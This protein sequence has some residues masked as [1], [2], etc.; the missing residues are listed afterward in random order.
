MNILIDKVIDLLRE[1]LKEPR[2]IKR[3]YFGNPEELASADL[4]CIFVQPLSKTVE[5]LDNVYDLIT[6]GFMVG[7]CVEVG[8][9]QR[10]NQ[11]EGTAE[12][13][14]T[15]IEGGRNTDGTPIQNSI[16]YVLRNHFT[17]EGTVLHQEQNTVWGERELTGGTAKEIHMY[18][19]AKIRVRNTS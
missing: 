8:K 10:K 9:Y 2:E 16:T 18:F 1:D 7:I 6:V 19:T 15:E 3:F 13:F 14:L 12:R 11:D 5:Q 4:P 17:M